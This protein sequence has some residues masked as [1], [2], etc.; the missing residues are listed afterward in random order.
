[1]WIEFLNHQQVVNRS[2]LDFQTTPAE[3]VLFSSDASKGKDLGFGCFFNGRWL[4]GQWEPGFI[5]E[6]DPSI[7]YLELFA[8]C[9]GIITWSENPSD[10]K[11]LIRCDNQ[12]TVQMV[13][14]LASPCKNCMYLLR[15]LMLDNLQRNRTIHCVYI[16]TKD[17]FLS[18]MLSRLT[19][20]RF[21]EVAPKG[22]SPMPDSLS[23]KL[24]PLTRIWQK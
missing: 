20:K 7:A 12:A 10:K 11:I 1:M 22:T 8:L 15:M 19:I 3:D 5:E 23:E 2:F 24:W 6:A 14:K 13:N 9:M 21:L 17:N 18:D 4:F 16:S